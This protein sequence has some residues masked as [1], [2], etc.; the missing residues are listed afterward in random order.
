MLTPQLFDGIKNI[1]R[2]PYEKVGKKLILDLSRLF[3]EY[4]NGFMLKA[5]AL[6]AAMIMPSI[7]LQHPNHQSK[8]KENL[9]C[10]ERRLSL[11]NDG[12]IS[13]LLLESQS[14]QNHLK[15]SKTVHVKENIGL[16]TL[17]TL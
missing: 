10:L 3:R 15:P 14:I 1:F 2:V 16:L 7:L 12:S 5:I 6:K 8:L 13:E 11:S 9:C 17:Q 4:A